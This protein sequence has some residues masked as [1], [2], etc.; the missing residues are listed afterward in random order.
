[1]EALGTNKAAINH[2]SLNV[3]SSPVSCGAALQAHVY[4]FAWVRTHVSLYVGLGVYDTGMAHGFEFRVYA[5]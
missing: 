2:P 4:R 5:Y 1:M 3:G